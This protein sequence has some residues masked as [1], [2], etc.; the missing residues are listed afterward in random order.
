LGL[1]QPEAIQTKALQEL[2]GWFG[3]QVDA[4]RS[5][6]IQHIEHALPEVG[7]H[8]GL[9]DLPRKGDGFFECGD[10]MMHGSVEGAL[11]SAEQT[12]QQ[13]LEALQHDDD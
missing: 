5:L 6:A 12:F 2:R 11:L 9:S 4:W 8:S 3:S 7:P 1:T 10:H 13:V